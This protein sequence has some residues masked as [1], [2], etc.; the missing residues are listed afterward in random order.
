VFILGAESWGRGR[1]RGVQFR[2]EEDICIEI[3]MVFEKKK[4]EIRFLGD[5]CRYACKSLKK[6]MRKICRTNFVAGKGF[7]LTKPLPTSEKLSREKGLSF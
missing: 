4:Q 7:I 2:V 3:E 6:A 5:Y 1:G